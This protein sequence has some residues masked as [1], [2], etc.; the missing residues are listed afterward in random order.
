MTDAGETRVVGIGELLWDLLPDGPRLG[1]APFNATANLARLGHDV[2]FVTVVGDDDLGHEAV[3]RARGLGVGTTWI[4]ETAAVPTGTV[5]V[6]LDASGGPRFRIVSPAA[7]E[8]IDLSPQR[9]AAIAAWRPRAVVFG[10]LAQRFPGV[11]GS[12]LA[13]IDRSA[14]P[15]RLYDINLREGCWSDELVLDLLSLAT[16]VKVN[17]DEAAVLGRLFGTSDDPGVLGPELGR[18]FGS[19]G[20]CVTRGGDGAALWL[21]GSLHDVEGIAIEVVD[22]VG[23]GDAFAAALLDGLLRERDPGDVLARA[24]RL[25]AVVASRSGALPDWSIEELDAAPSRHG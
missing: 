19:R 18:R 25:G 23:A 17:G 9:L 4:A 20:L 5:E 15:V 7:Y 16:I 2:Q 24:N 11:L 13:I 10:T 8:T 12:T 3:L 21:D 14:A 1:G 22:A 6:A